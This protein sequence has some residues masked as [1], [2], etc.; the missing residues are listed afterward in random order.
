MNFIYFYLGESENA[1]IVSCCLSLVITILMFIHTK[2]NNRVK[3]IRDYILSIFFLLIGFF[4]LKI[5]D[6]KS[7]TNNISDFFVLFLACLY[8]F[9][10]CNKLI[11]EL[12]KFIKDN[13]LI[14]IYENYTYNESL[15]LKLSI[16]EIK[17]IKDE[18]EIEK[19][20][21]FYLKTE[22][23]KMEKVLEYYLES[24]FKENK[25]FICYLYLKKSNGKKIETIKKEYDELTK[26]QEK[27]YELVFG[28]I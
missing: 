23:K 5:F 26:N 3:K 18:T 6:N 8:F 27:F 11:K 2:Q 16:E 9:E 12:K 28:A 10:R 7:K 1:I 17:N 4:S 21:I 24:G 15:K 20:F 25:E 22:D 13:Y 19:Q 14:Y